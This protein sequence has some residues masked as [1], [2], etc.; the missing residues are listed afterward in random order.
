MHNCW[1]PEG[2]CDQIDQTVRGFIWGSSTSHWVPWETIT[3]SRA[4]GGLGVRKAR[5]ANISLLGKHI[6][7]VIHN[8]DKLWVKLMTN[9]YLN[10]NSIFQSMS[11]RGATFTWSS[12]LKATNFLK[13]GFFI[14]I[15]RGDVSLWYGKWL[16]EGYLCSKVLYVNYQDTH[17]RVKDLWNNGSWNFSMLATILPNDMK[18]QIR[19]IRINDI[20][21]D[22]IIWAPSADG[23]YSASTVYKWLTSTPSTID[24]SEVSWTWLWSLNIPENI[25]FFLWLSLHE[26]LPTNMFRVYRHLSLDVNCCRCGLFQKDILHLLRDFQKAKSIWSYL[27]WPRAMLLIIITQKIGF[28]TTSKE[29]KAFS[30]P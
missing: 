6:W 3:Q 2:I 26:S 17:L 14:R 18:Q 12:I 11:P 28:R 9:K 22:I 21:D 16:L 25:R 20:V 23:I 1:R 24:T 5:E 15:G 7:E 13:D 8:P 27:N 29:I 30:F 19:S 10:H 4:R